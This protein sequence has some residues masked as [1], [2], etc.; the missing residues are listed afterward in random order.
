MNKLMIAVL[1]TFIC[2][3]TPAWAVKVHSLYEVEMSVPSQASDS[4]SEAIRDGFHEVLIKLTGNQNIDKNKVIKSSLNKADYYVQEYSYSSPTVSSATYTLRI[5]YNEQDVKRLLRKAGASVWGEARPLILVW[6]VTINDR[7]EVDILG[8][9]TEHAML[10]KFKREG[11]RFGL[12]LIFPVM[13]VADMEKVTSENVT[14]VALPELKEASRRYEPDALLIG[15][16]E[17]DGDVYNGRWSLV[18]GEKSWEWN[19]EG[20]SREKVIATVLDNISQVLS[21][22]HDAKSAELSQ[23]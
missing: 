7:H 3:C 6:L 16:L 23:K 2:L 20:E 21:Q 8:V 1:L 15:T 14:A 19:I 5:K 4:R 12:P 11:Q 13:D 18:W 17:N 9:E 10:E 22:R